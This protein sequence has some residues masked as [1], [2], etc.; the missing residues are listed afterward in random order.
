VGGLLPRLD[1]AVPSGVVPSPADA[2]RVVG[3]IDLTG[4]LLGTPT[5]DV[6]VGLYRA[7]RVVRAFDTFVYPPGPMTQTQM[8]LQITEATAVLPG[9][10]RVIL[11]VN[12]QQALNSPEVDL[13][14]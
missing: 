2:T 12:G 11:R 13:V 10:Y 5:D 7:G 9:P 14:P 3:D 6:F 8:R 4:I 1:T